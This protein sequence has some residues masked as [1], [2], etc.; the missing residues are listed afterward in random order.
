M[1]KT[2]ESNASKLL[3]FLIN[4]KKE[5]EWILKFLNWLEMVKEML[6]YVQR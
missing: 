1:S 6:V 5:S 4:L 3:K 2:K